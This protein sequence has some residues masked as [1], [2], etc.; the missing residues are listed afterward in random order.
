MNF[1]KKGIH[2]WFFLQDGVVYTRTITRTLAICSF[3]VRLFIHCKV[4]QELEVCCESC[5]YDHNMELMVTKKQSNFRRKRRWYRSVMGTYQC[6]SS[7]F[8]L[9]LESFKCFYL[10]IQLEIGYQ[11]CNITILHLL[12]CNSLSINKIFVSFSKKMLY[13][14]Y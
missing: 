12:R 10:V 13:Y 7:F 9:E 4:S 11:F 3:I 6:Q 5:Y 1:Y 14:I 8:I 2:S